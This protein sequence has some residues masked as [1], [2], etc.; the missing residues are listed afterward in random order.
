MCGINA[1]ISDDNADDNEGIFDLYE[2]L[3][4]LQHRGQD[5]FGLSYIGHNSQKIE[6]LKYNTLLSSS[7]ID[8][9]SISDSIHMGI[10]HVRY[11]TSGKVTI[12]ECQP[13][14]L[15]GKHFNISF[16]HNGQIWITESLK[17]FF[18]LNKIIISQTN[19]SD[20]IYLLYILSFY[21]NEYK[22]LTSDIIVDIVNKIQNLV[23]GSYN[24]I[25]LIDNFGLICFKDQNSIRPLIYGEKK[26]N[27]SYIIASESV[28]IT[29]IGY[30]IIDDIY[31][32]DLLIFHKNKNQPLDKRILSSNSIFKPCIFEWVY[33]AR[34]ESIL[35]SVNVYRAR[36]KMGEY[37]AHKII[38]EIDI[39]KVD[40][41]VPVPDTSKPVALSV[42][43]ILNIPYYEC[44][45]KNRYVNRTFI[46]NTQKERGKNIKRK[47]NVIQEFIM[48]KNLL[49][50]DDSIVR[51]NTMKH[52]VKLL[53]ENGSNEIYVA[54]SCPEIVNKNVYGIDIPDKNELI[55]H[56][57][58]NDN[59]CREFNINHIIFQNLSD[60]KKSIQYFNK[61]IND[62]ED[63]VFI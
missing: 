11:P 52:I 24:C 7:K 48:N 26:D 58:T 28:S 8:M 42:S 62:F 23:Q 5:S 13:F 63:S 46:M 9:G 33:L 17:E 47:L 25:C 40:Y 61:N 14:Y 4:H 59:I 31:G 27:K 39:S 55:C 32:N 15:E 21:I 51:G 37:L 3:Y 22:S 20:S 36:L 44:I 12:N 19:T 54:S 57:L 43:K 45:T 60:L 18:K 16:V 49:I 53:K 2:S 10:G 34:E 41:V 6:T 56:T 29:G 1:I 50:I 30:D 35:Y 38:D